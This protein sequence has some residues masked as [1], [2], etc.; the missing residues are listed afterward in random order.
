M[1]NALCNNDS[2]LVVV[3]G[4]KFEI[5]STK[6]ETYKQV[7]TLYNLYDFVINYKVLSTSTKYSVVKSHGVLRS[8]HCVDIVIRHLSAGDAS[9][10]GSLDRF[11]FEISRYG[12]EEIYGRKEIIFRVVKTESESSKSLPVGERPVNVRHNHA[13]IARKLSRTYR[14]SAEELQEENS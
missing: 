7:V 5:V 2:L 11:L 9:N 13:D 1:N 12:A 8:H 14:P 10:V 4:K 3:S 6:P